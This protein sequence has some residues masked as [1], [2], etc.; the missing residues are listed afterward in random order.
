MNLAFYSDGSNIACSFRFNVISKNELYTN[1]S[2]FYEKSNGFATQLL[3]VKLNLLNF[4]SI[5]VSFG[6]ATL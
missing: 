1:Y 5:L 6:T 2:S 4:F 3:V